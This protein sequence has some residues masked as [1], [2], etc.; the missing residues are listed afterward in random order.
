MSEFVVN[1]S[2]RI[3]VA[4]KTRSRKLLRNVQFVSI[5]KQFRIKAFIFRVLRIE[6]CVQNRPLHLHNG[7]G[8]CIKFFK[9][10]LEYFKS[11]THTEVM[12]SFLPPAI[13]IVNFIKFS[14]KWVFKTRS[15]AIKIIHSWNA[16]S[17][18]RNRNGTKPKKERSHAYKT[19]IPP[20]KPNCTYNAYL[21]YR[22]LI[23]N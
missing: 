16:K 1:L 23:S 10:L 4:Q 22:G 19:N 6:F 20:K 5:Y 15:K 14:L 12:T 2:T 3:I 18:Q 9:R 11:S 8:N 13:F 17:C 21:A 7:F